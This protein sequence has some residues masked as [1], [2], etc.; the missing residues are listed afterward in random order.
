M[1]RSINKATIYH[2]LV[3]S[4]IIIQLLSLI[5][6]VNLTLLNAVL[7]IGVSILGIQS[8]SRSF[9]VATL[10]FF[11]AG[12][13]LLS[14]TGLSINGL[15]MAITSMVDIVVLLV[16]MQLFLI[17]VTIGNYQATVEAFMQKHIR[18]PK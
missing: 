14:T 6:P 5:V 12:L 18:G 1:E 4:L 15:A 8:L 17:P 13:G 9:Q 2:S 10:I 16:V 7:A 3:L 11:I